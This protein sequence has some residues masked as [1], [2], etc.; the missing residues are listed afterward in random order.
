VT[1]FPDQPDPADSPRAHETSAAG[2]WGGPTYSYRGTRIECLKGGHVCGL[3]LDGHPLTGLTF[4]GIGTVTPL[5][6]L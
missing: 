6:D 1:L 2:P 4:G 3:V 5:V